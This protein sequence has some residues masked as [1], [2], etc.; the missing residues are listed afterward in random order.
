M[1]ATVNGKIFTTH[2]KF[3][4]T[5][6][7]PYHKELLF[8]EQRIKRVLKARGVKIIFMKNA[9]DFKNNFSFSHLKQSRLRLKEHP[10]LFIDYC[11]LHGS[12]QAQANMWILFLEK[13]YN[14]VKTSYYSL[15][16]YKGLIKI[17]FQFT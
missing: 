5:S 1:A 3:Y 15:I 10:I 11:K 9:V 12:F 14:F 17:Y 4:Q 8:M 7:C 2:R 13:V 6:L 16:R